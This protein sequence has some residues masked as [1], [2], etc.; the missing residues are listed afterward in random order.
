MSRFET[1]TL[2]I[3]ERIGLRPAGC[4]TTL[5][6][7]HNDDLTYLP[8]GESLAERERLWTALATDPEGMAA[9]AAHRKHHG[10]VVANIAS[11]FLSPTVFS[12]PR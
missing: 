5:V 6:G 2:G 10:E 4:L 8:A 9:L 11:S 12:T 3:W 1:T 7:P